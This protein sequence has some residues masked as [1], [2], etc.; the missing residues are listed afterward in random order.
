MM[1]I[2][3]PPK[4][5]IILNPNSKHTQTQNI[6]LSKTPNT[7]TPE[8]LAS[9]NLPFVYHLVDR[10]FSRYYRT[11]G[12]PREILV[13]AGMMGLVVAANRSK[14]GTFLRYASFWIRYYIYAEIRGFFAIKRPAAY[15]AK[16]NKIRKFQAKYS[17]DHGGQRPSYE[18]LSH[19]TGY[20]AEIIEGVLSFDE[21]NATSVV[22]FDEFINEDEGHGKMDRMMAE[23][24]E[25]SEVDKSIAIADCRSAM[26]KCL[27][28]IEKAAVVMKFV[29]EASNVEIAK[30]IQV[31]KARAGRI[32]GDAILKLRREL[33]CG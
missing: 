2:L 17:N 31:S 26:D 10:E 13:S 6:A 5:K 4:E 11:V 22:S 19:Q 8:Q 16:L 25:T 3:T 30:K 9:E 21:A 7:K 12:I 29:D 27:T 28:D 14:Y 18:W 20:P 15:C 1:E 24:E 32:V 33:A 23:V